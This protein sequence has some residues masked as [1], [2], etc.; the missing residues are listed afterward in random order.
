[1]VAYEEL[2]IKDVSSLGSGTFGH[3]DLAWSDAK[4]EYFAQKKFNI[5]DVD[6]FVVQ[7]NRVE[8]VKREKDVLQLCSSPF[9]V[10]LI[11]T[12]MDKFSLFLVMEFAHGGE[13]R[14]YLYDMS[15]KELLEAVRFYVTEV[16]CALK[17]IHSKSVNYSTYVNQFN[18]SIEVYRDLKPENLLLSKE[19]H[20]KLTDFGLAKVLKGKTYTICG[21]A[22]YIAPEVFLRKGYGVDVDW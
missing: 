12:G 4:H 22:E 2:L 15:E 18:H 3:V 10:K 20:V 13:L 5:N 21:T 6:F 17:H 19:G 9:I 16:V 8:Y 14:D 1:M 11:C 7:E